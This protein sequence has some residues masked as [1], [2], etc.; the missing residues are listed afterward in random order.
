M[1]EIHPDFSRCSIER[2]IKIEWSNRLFELATQGDGQSDAAPSSSH[3]DVDVPFRVNCEAV[4]C[5][6]DIPLTPQPCTLRSLFPSEITTLESIC[7]CKCNKWSALRILQRS[8]EVNDLSPILPTYVSDTR[9]DGTVVLIYINSVNNSQE[10]RIKNYNTLIDRMFPTGIHGCTVLSNSMIHFNTAK[11]HRCSIISHTYIEPYSTVINCTYLA[12]SSPDD[13]IGTTAG[14]KNSTVEMLSVSVG[15]ESGGGR[16]LQLNPES[17]M[18]TIGQQIVGASRLQPENDSSEIRAAH[19]NMIGSH[20]IVRDTPTLY[21]VYLHPKSSIIA[22]TSV[23]QALL[24]PGSKIV[25]CSTARNVILQWDCTIT[26]HSYVSDVFFMEQAMAG[27]QSTVTNSVLGPD[28]HISCGEVHASVLGPNTNSHHQSLVI[29]TLWLCGRGNV[30]YGSNVGSNHTGRIPDQEC[31]AGEGVFWGLSSVIKFPVD[32]TWAP[33][34]I[35]AAGTTLAPQ[36]CTMPFSLIMNHQRSGSSGTEIVPGWVLRYSPYTVVRS[37]Q[38]FAQ[39]RKAKRH[40]NYTGWKIIRPEVVHQCYVARQQ[41][42]DVVAATTTDDDDALIYSARDISGIGANQMTEKGRLLG[43]QAYSELIQQFALQ[44]F[45][46][47]LVDGCDQWS[48]AS[49]LDLLTGEFLSKET[50]SAKDFD[51]SA[52]VVWPTFPW[53]DGNA[54]SLWESQRFFL[55]Q[56]FSL[57]KDESILE[58]VQ[59]LLEKHIE[60]EIAFSDRV[61]Q[62][63]QRD[64]SRGVATIPGYAET[65]VSVTEDTIVISL[66]NG[67]DQRR[68]DIDVLLQKLAN[69]L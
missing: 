50:L 65:H 14:R 56:E 19:F 39:R 69:Y 47:F 63:K 24:F 9:F 48:K 3:I 16:L 64:N 67:L 27:P 6:D 30:G 33:Y 21:G 61:H 38:K 55:L 1:K 11:V 17:T 18:I 57:S 41:L 36:R 66:K 8:Q 23:N 35:V 20:C 12:M 32:L 49:L 29:A 42:L 40:S 7:R 31:C 10:E 25:N 62:C 34:T 5:C 54:S 4:D 53:D 59:N 51:G 43:L 37:E 28:V 46:R 52:A 58:W 26:D 13:D 45:Y 68:H 44:G 60:L 22:A 2:S 15:A